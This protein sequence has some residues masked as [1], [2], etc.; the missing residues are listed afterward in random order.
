MKKRVTK[1]QPTLRELSD[2]IAFIVKHMATKE[3]I[4]NMAT[5]EDIRNMA[6]KDDIRNMATKEDIRNMA[7]KDDMAGIREELKDIKFRLKDVEDAVE[8]H[9]G[10]TREID[11]ALERISVIERKLGIKHR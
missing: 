6:T 4:R 1:N 7:T 3:D 9:A 2:Q 5:K 8:N 11:Y 10:H